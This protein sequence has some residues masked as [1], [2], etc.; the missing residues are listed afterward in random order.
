MLFDV[1]THYDLH[2]HNV[3]LYSP[4][5]NSYIDFC[6]TLP[7]GEKIQFNCP[8][9]VKIIDYGKSFFNDKTNSGSFTGSSENF[10][11]YFNDIEDCQDHAAGLHWLYREKNNQDNHFIY[12]RIPNHS[13]DLK[14][15]NFIKKFY[16]NNS[17]NVPLIFRDLFD[18]L[19]YRNENGVISRKNDNTN[20]QIRTCTDLYTFLKN[21]LLNTNFVL[22]SNKTTDI[23][24]K[25]K[26]GTLNVYAEN[27]TPMEFVMEKKKNR[28]EKVKTIPEKEKENKE[29]KINIAAAPQPIIP[30]EKREF[31]DI[32]NLLNNEKLV[33][34][35]YEEVTN[36]I[37]TTIHDILKS[38]TVTEAN[39]HM[40]NYYTNRSKIIDEN[41]QRKYLVKLELA[42]SENEENQYEFEK[43]F[44]KKNKEMLL[45][46]ENLIKEENTFLTETNF[47]EKWEELK[48]RNPDQANVINATLLSLNNP[49]QNVQILPVN[50]DLLNY[51]TEMLRENKELYKNWKT[52]ED[53]MYEKKQ[54]VDAFQK[55]YSDTYMNTFK[56]EEIDPLLKDLEFEAKFF[57][58]GRLNN[59]I[60]NLIN[61]TH[62]EIEENKTKIAANDKNYRLH[63]VKKNY[64]EKRNNLITNIQKSIQ[65]IIKGYEKEVKNFSSGKYSNEQLE[66]FNNLIHFYT[67]ILQAYT[68]TVRGNDEI[69]NGYV[70]HAQHVIC[71]AEYAIQKYILETHLAL[72]ETIYLSPHTGC[73]EIKKEMQ[74]IINSIFEKIKRMEHDLLDNDQS[75]LEKKNIY[76]EKKAIGIAKIIE[77]YIN[78]RNKCIEENL[79]K[80]KELLEKAQEDKKHFPMD[81][82]YQH[83]CELEI[84]EL[85]LIIN[86][87]TQIMDN[88]SLLPTENPEK[89][90]GK[91]SFQGDICI[92]ETNLKKI[93][94]LKL[95]KKEELEYEKLHMNQNDNI[96]DFRE[97]INKMRLAI[98]FNRGVIDFDKLREKFHDSKK[99]FFAKK[100]DFLRRNKRFNSLKQFN[101][102]MQDNDPNNYDIQIEKFINNV[103]DEI[104][105]K[106][107]PD[108]FNDKLIGAEETIKKW[109]NIKEE[110]KTVYKEFFDMNTFPNE[111]KPYSELQTFISNI[112][113]DNNRKH[114]N[115]NEMDTYTKEYFTEFTSHTKDIISTK[116]KEITKENNDTDLKEQNDKNFRTNKEKFITLQASFETYWN[117]VYLPFSN[118]FR[119]ENDKNLLGLPKMFNKAYDKE[120]NNYNE[121]ITSN[122]DFIYTFDSEN[123][124]YI[125]IRLQ[126]IKETYLN[127]N[128]TGALLPEITEEDITLF[129]KTIL[130]NT[131]KINDILTTVS[132]K[133]LQFKLT[134]AKEIG[135][136]ILSIPPFNSTELS[137]LY[138]KNEK[139]Y[140]REIAIIQNLD[141]QLSVEIIKQTESDNFPENVEEW[142]LNISHQSFLKNLLIFIE[143]Q[144]R[145]V[146][147]NEEQINILSNQYPNIDYTIIN[148]NIFILELD[149]KKYLLF[150]KQDK[151]Q[152]HYHHLSSL[153][154]SILAQQRN[155]IYLFNQYQSKMSE[156]VQK[157]N[158]LEQL[159]ETKNNIRANLKNET[160][161][162]EN[163]VTFLQ[164]EIQNKYLIASQEI[165]LENSQQVIGTFYNDCDEMIKDI[166]RR[167]EN[168]KREAEEKQKRDAE[169]VQRAVEKQKREAEEK[170]IEDAAKETKKKEEDA[171]KERKD[172]DKLVV[173][174]LLTKFLIVYKDKLNDYNQ[175]ETHSVLKNLKTNI[176]KYSNSVIEKIEK[177]TGTFHDANFVPTLENAKEIVTSFYSLDIIN[178]TSELENRIKVC[179]GKNTTVTYFIPELENNQMILIECYNQ[180]VEF[181]NT[182]QLENFKNSLE[183]Y[184]T[185]I[186]NINSLLTEIERTINE[187][188]V[189][190]AEYE[191]TYEKLNEDTN[192]QL[193]K[194]KMEE[195]KSHLIVHHTIKQ[196]TNLNSNVYQILRF[197]QEIVE[198]K[199]N[200]FLNLEFLSVKYLRIFPPSKVK[201]IFD[202]QQSKSEY[203]YM[204]IIGNQLLSANSYINACIDYNHDKLMN[205]EKEWSGYLLN[206]LD[207][208]YTNFEETI[209]VINKDRPDFN[210]GV[211][212]DTNASTNN[213]SDP[214]IIDILKELAKKKTMTTFQ[215]YVKNYP[216]FKEND[217]NEM[218]Y[219]PELR[220]Q[221]TPDDYREKLNT[222]YNPVFVQKV[223]EKYT[224][225]IS[226]N[227]EKLETIEQKLQ[228]LLNMKKQIMENNAL[229]NHKTLVKITTEFERLDKLL[230]F[231]Q[232][233]I[234]D[235]IKI[236][237]EDS[238]KFQDIYHWLETFMKEKLTRIKKILADDEERKKLQLQTKKRI[239]FSHEKSD[240]EKS[241]NN[242]KKKIQRV[243]GGKYQKTKKIRKKL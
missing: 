92:S 87:Y 190:Q 101:K 45:E 15:V 2:L 54:A 152:E 64:V 105:D 149:I 207:E 183:T 50:M 14:L 211:E 175:N 239:Q 216:N 136:M 26:L 33:F 162:T 220:K 62:A 100:N 108:N 73:I 23:D 20:K 12:S 147:S 98:S 48:K 4:K 154:E 224:D 70:Q 243:K 141:K 237:E 1:Y 232:S 142:K 103:F 132:S 176:I 41:Y 8:Y 56:K 117:D 51:L 25:E 129:N 40:K 60:I 71:S 194:S 213:P 123:K 11:Q 164:N 169:E 21:Y 217:N 200:F 10:F 115:M 72:E 112:I 66:I 94:Y 148:Q 125:P 84:N 34:T 77:E 241:E 234:R 144:Y 189:N 157:K 32:F 199:N 120:L 18:K 181:A 235:N 163:A 209:D 106:D 82:K 151:L 116:I 242:N 167:I 146:K 187:I 158:I 193:L 85:G 80:K 127:K 203:D 236:T 30:D 178:A 198:Y 83:I 165:T 63:N 22:Q 188:N 228:I 130:D 3:L 97:W 202:D 121:F 161:G 166:K 212:E 210:K 118:I 74:S 31:H 223:V 55:N 9:L 231:F 61:E 78:K 222:E 38:S 128:L 150:V 16:T 91:T 137:L 42:N 191:K 140:E 119:E 221:M 28:V 68:I 93:L 156:E 75:D 29:E 96:N 44:N 143:D 208:I 201:Q 229:I 186:R 168:Q 37:D 6:Y 104:I 52:L 107:T 226:E 225:E 7:G 69:G 133:D 46:I 24:G 204:K 111:S 81:D 182:V 233:C 171:E 35:H 76:F 240:H 5:E 36:L 49:R 192:R 57:K 89:L 238:K 145:N 173:N 90:Y 214:K 138:K 131:K 215:E 17:Y 177:S 79:V 185:R 155:I 205:L 88:T 179:K 196:I 13:H 122:N 139:F 95:L 184:K 19:V 218:N 219:F 124:R 43:T 170:K 172:K 65:N 99:K 58:C 113:E 227:F 110:F 206:T 59:S 134:K 126:I 160:L 47:L 109:K 102:E 27:E 230:V 197:V 86:Y 39:N 195:Y 174:E 67:E 159:N 114:V 153:F 53:T 180:M 135:S